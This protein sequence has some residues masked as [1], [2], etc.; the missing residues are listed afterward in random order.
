MP[1]TE[2]LTDPYSESAERAVLGCILLDGSSIKSVKGDL[3]ID[4]FHHTHHRMIY[5][6][7]LDLYEGTMAID[8]V[9][10]CDRLKELNKLSKAGGATLLSELLDET[11]SSANIN[12][13]VKIVKEKSL[14]RR[15]VSEAQKII[16]KAHAPSAK[17]EDIETK[18]S[19]EVRRNEE[20]LPARSII[21]QLNNNIKKGYPGLY[22][23][24]DLLS[25]TIRKV[26]PGH[27]WVVGGYTSVGKSAWLVDFICRMY[28]HMMDNPGIAIFSTEMSAEQYMIRMLSNHTGLAGWNITENCVPRDKQSDL[29]KAQ[30]FYSERNL[31]IYD[32]IY[33]VEDIERMARTLKEKRLDILAIDY[34]QNMW[35]EGTLYERMSRMAPILQYMAKEL[36]ITIIALSQ[37]SNE[38][39]RNKSGVYGY[40]GAGEIAASADLGIELTRDQGNKELLKFCVEKNRHGAVDETYLQY[41]NKFTRLHEQVNGE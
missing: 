18:L 13:Y 31:Y 9:T 8:L 10:V 38:H 17:P 37:V 11:A 21:T 30:I 29:V 4:D 35:G 36:Q 7:M 12:H 2:N 39:V 19:I 15:I 6:A 23:C 20:V 33:K 3:D 25:K 28:R 26:S 40:K 1:K 27:L 32:R 41:V 34:L 16:E 24:Y 22:P 14:L 5:S